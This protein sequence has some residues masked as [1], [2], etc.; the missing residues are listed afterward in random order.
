MHAILA[1]FFAA[2]FSFCH[3]STTQQAINHPAVISNDPT[4]FS[5]PAVSSVVSPQTAPVYADGGCVSCRTMNV[6]YSVR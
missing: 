2:I 4:V 3:A 5:T 1:A 6:S